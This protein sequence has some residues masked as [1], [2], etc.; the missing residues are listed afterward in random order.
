MIQQRFSALF[1]WRDFSTL[2]AKVMI[3]LMMIEVHHLLA[4]PAST[5]IMETALFNGWRRAICVPC[6]DTQ[7]QRCHDTQCQR[8][9]MRCRC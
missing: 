4:C 1:A 5:F 9:E 2:T 3:T 8:Q 7:C 6:A